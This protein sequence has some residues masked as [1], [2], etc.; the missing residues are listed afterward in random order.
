MKPYSVVNAHRVPDHDGHV[1]NRADGPRALPTC[2]HPGYR[3]RQ[4]DASTAHPPGPLTNAG[5]ASTGE[6]VGRV[7]MSR[8]HEEDEALG[9]FP[10]SL[11]ALPTAP[12]LLQAY[13]REIGSVPRLTAEQE[14]ALAKRVEAG[15]KKA[16]QQLT[17]HNLRLVVSVA[18]KYF[19]RDLALLDLIQEGNLGLMKAVQKYDWRRGYRFS[20]CAQ[21]WIRQAIVRAIA[22]KGRPIR[23]PVHIMETLGKVEGATE[24]LAIVLGRTPTDDELAASLG[25]TTNEMR[26]ARKAALLHTVSLQATVDEDEGSMLGDMIVDDVA[27]P[28][29]RAYQR[30]LRDE[31]SHILDAVLTPRERTVVQLHFGLGEGGVYT[32]EE[33]G[34]M[35]G[36]TRERVRQVEAEALLK[37][38]T[39]RIRRHLDDAAREQTPGRGIR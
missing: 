13:F 10:G 14:V 5:A 16:A 1:G 2:C 8:R 11:A 4:R 9:V 35:L 31:I 19:G 29:E 17:L 21:W 30:I 28:E 22:D 37:L 32:L 38:R 23:L 6:A 18:K 36:L 15:D 3:C 33:I 25:R 26:Y 20:T 34:E 39:P 7:Q 24:H 12:N 27:A